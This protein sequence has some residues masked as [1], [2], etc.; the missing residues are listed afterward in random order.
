MKNKKLIIT[1]SIVAVVVLIAGIFIGN[2]NSLSNKFTTVEEKQANIQAELQR[3]NDLIP[4]LVRTVEE[5]AEHENQTLMGVTEAR[6]LNA[7]C[8]EVENADTI[9]EQAAA[10]DKVNEAYGIYVN[11]VSEA[12]PNIQA[13]KNF[14]SLQSQLEATENRIVQARRTYNESVTSYNGAIRRFPGNIFAS[15]FGFEKAQPFEAAAG[16]DKVPEVFAD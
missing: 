15:M 13:Y 2:Y 14:E 8:K 6:A 1:L 7:A 3:R 16:A 11:A 10:N 5:Y 12:Y 4:N 9:A